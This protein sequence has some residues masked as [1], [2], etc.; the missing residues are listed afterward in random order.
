MPVKLKKF[1]PTATTTSTS[2][3]FINP[4]G[5][6]ANPVNPRLAALQN[7]ATSPDPNVKPTLPDG[8][9]TSYKSPLS[10][11]EQKIY[12]AVAQANQFASKITSPLQKFFSTVNT[13][14]QSIDAVKGIVG[15]RGSVQRA[16]NQAGR[17]VGADIF[18]L[19]K[20]NKFKQPVGD[21]GPVAPLDYP[22]PRIAWEIT[23]QWR[24]L[25]GK[26]PI[27]F[28]VNPN[29]IT[30][31]QNLIEATEQVQ[32]GF[33]ITNWK[34]INVAKGNRFPKLEISF[35]FQSS[36]IL[37]ESYAKSKI[38]FNDSST[39]TDTIRQFVGAQQ[40][41]VI[42]IDKP[43]TIPPGLLNFFDILSIFH[44][45]RTI[46]KLSLY[47]TPNSLNDQKE[48]T[49]SDL[50]QITPTNINS[51]IENFA[52]APNYVY[53]SI[54]TRV[55]PKM[56]M[57]GYFK[58]GYSLTESANSPLSFGTTLNFTAFETD[59]AW[60]DIEKIKSSYKTF[61]NNQTNQPGSIPK[62][63]LVPDISKEFNRIPKATLEKAVQQN[64][65]ASQFNT[66]TT[67]QSTPTDMTGQSAT[68]NKKSSYYISGILGDGTLGWISPN[69]ELTNDEY[70]QLLKDEAAA[71][72]LGA[73]L[74]RIIPESV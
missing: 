53:L 51:S 73:F 70:D 43:Y 14:N 11:T 44:E 24:I 62:A 68:P 45:D 12:N 71:E 57:K 32:K 30:Y 42:D 3:D 36:N 61:Y 67:V 1:G 19:K 29:T 6:L 49:Y 26:P 35:G 66:E 64:S 27:K 8:T 15:E 17:I 33:I 60:W 46:S 52:G 31:T 21:A 40:D 56:T 54:S 9:Q 69:G 63:E 65:S 39:L 7:V 47:N 48:N 50:S 20:E 4:K 55:Y 13:I 10:A 2:T 72:Q 37:P 41:K 23:T 74:N 59:P 28:Y 25:T 34:D 58:N 16:L 38:D 22:Y 5:E 18:S